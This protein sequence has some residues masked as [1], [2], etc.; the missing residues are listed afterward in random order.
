MRED[1]KIS[2]HGEQ[3]V[4]LGKYILGFVASLALTLMAYLLV[5][6]RAASTDT[7][8][9]IICGL[10]VIQFLVQMVFFLH[11]G[12]E[13]KPRWKQ[14]VMWFMF[15]IIFLIIGGSI[16]IMNN[17]NT[18]MTPKQMQQYMKSQDAL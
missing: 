17:L 3:H 11:I 5:T 6:R 8:M 15:A 16:W 7:L 1:V 9:A 4:S 13:R 18:R 14:M 10:A 2:E 12:E